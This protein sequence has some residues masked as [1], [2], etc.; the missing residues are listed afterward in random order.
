VRGLPHAD[1]REGS[2]KVSDLYVPSPLLEKMINNACDRDGGS[3][4][5]ADAGGDSKGQG[6]SGAI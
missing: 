5:A 2:I 3:G 6:A 4:D 1:L